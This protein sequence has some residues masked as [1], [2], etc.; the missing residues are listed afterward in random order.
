MNRFD[1]HAHFAPES[2]PAAS[3]GYA[4]RMRREGFVQGGPDMRWSPES[5]LAFMA[6]RGIAMQLLSMPMGLPAEQARATNE[7]AAR[8]VADRPSRFGLLA[9]VPLAEPVRAVE[10]VRYAA[11]T[12]GADGFVLMTNHGGAYLGDARFEPVFAELDRRAASVFVHPAAPAPFGLLG[13]GRPAPL[14][15]F[16]MDTARTVV[17]ALFAGLFLR[18]PGIRFILAHAGGVLPALSARLLSLGTKEWVDNPHGVTRDQLAAQ[19]ASLYFDTAIAGTAV[20]VAPAIEVAGADH[21]VFGTDFPPAGVDVVDQTIAELRGSLG[22]G[23][24]RGLEETFGTLF[25]A[26]V[27][28]VAG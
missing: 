13:L 19:L 2:A 21:L 1:V 4:E 26:A 11:D 10:E 25:P 12:L 5:A 27:A 23:D 22:P 24:Q 7:H 16:P 14:I 20:T 3:V 18:H 6:E 17:D 8:I 9:S 28:R 15:E